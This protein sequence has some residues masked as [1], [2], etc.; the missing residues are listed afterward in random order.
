MKTAIYLD[1]IRTPTQNLEG[2]KPWSVVRNYEEFVQHIELNGIPDLISFDHD[3]ADEHM[4]DYW[5]KQARGVETISYD[6]FKEKTGLDC[7]DWLIEHVFQY[8]GH[9]VTPFIVWVHSHNPIGGQNILVKASNFMRHMGWKPQVH[10]VRP[11]FI[12]ET[13][14]ED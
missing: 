1:D 8:N 9:E 12:I 6:S 10:F 14:I 4:A 3:L 11:E 13:K 5:D 7:L 2:Y